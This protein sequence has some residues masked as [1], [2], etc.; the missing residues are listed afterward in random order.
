MSTGFTPDRVGPHPGHVRPTAPVAVIAR[1]KSPSS[2]AW[3]LY[4]AIMTVEVPVYY[5]ANNSVS[6]LVYDS[7]GLSSAMVIYVGLRMNRPA[8]RGPWLGFAMGT[9]LF[10]LGDVL[11]Y[12]MLGSAAPTVS[13]ANILYLAAYPAFAIGMF[14]LV[15]ARSPKAQFISTLDGLII[16]LA[17][18]A[19]AWTFVLGQYALDDTM[20]VAARF[21]AIIYPTLDIMLVVFVVRLVFS[22]GSRNV[23]YW[24]LLSSVVV[25][26][27][28]DTL[29]TFATVHNWFSLSFANPIDIGWLASYALWGASAL[30]PS[31]AN[32]AA[33]SES[34]QSRHPRT[35]LVLL[36]AAAMTAPIAVVVRELQGEHLDVGILTV[37]SA[38]IFALIVV[39]M[40]LVSKYLESAND[41]LADAVTRQTVFANTAEALVGASDFESVARAGVSAAVALSQ[42]VN[43]WATFVVE[44]P[45]VPIVV[46]ECG[47]SLSAPLLFAEPVT[48]DNEVRGT[49]NVG[50]AG[51]VH[52]DLSP[53]FRLIS[54]EMGLALKGVESTEERFRQ[55]NER[56]FR[57]LVQKST[58]LVTLIDRDGRILYQSPCVEDML[59]RNPEHMIGQELSTLVHPDDVAAYEN[60]LTKIRRSK[61]QDTIE[62]E[63]R[64]AHS[65]GSWRVVDSHMTNLLDDP[66]VGAILLNSRDVTDRRSLEQQLQHQAFHDSLT[67]LANRAL[68]IDRLDRALVRS[69]R[70]TASVAV[71]FLDVDDFKSI[72]DSLGHE[73]GDR[74]LVA[75]GE[76]LA[77]EIRLGDT[78]ARIGGDEFAV[79]VDL[80]ASSESADAIATRILRAFDDG[81]QI[82][83]E[84]VSVQLSIGI[85]LNGPTAESPDV[86]VRNAD[87]AMYTAKRKGKDRCETFEEEMYRDAAHRYDLVTDLRHALVNGELEVYYQPIIALLDSRVVGAEAL[88]RWNRRG[89]GMIPAIEFIEIAESTQLIIPL[90]EWV[91]DQACTQS[92]Q[93]KDRG[94]VDDAFFMSVNLSPRQ[95]GDPNI[96]ERVS[97][98]LQSSKLPA[99]A[100]VLEITES[101]ILLEGELG[102]DQIHRLKSL[103]VRL[104][105]DDY[106]TGYSSLSRLADLPLEIVKIDKSFI[107]R[108]T[109]EGAGR[110]LVQSIIDVTSALGMSCIAEGVELEAQ[111]IALIE[112]GCDNMQGYLFSEPLPA[113]EVDLMLRVAAITNPTTTA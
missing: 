90:G 62:L 3:W 106:G 111:R 89:V 8:K 68:F 14:L 97:S 45:L 92:Q 107:D 83:N 54:V 48:V 15:R 10:A 70:H 65:D 2:W 72:N 49:L 12:A 33:P 77:L 53:L 20:S 103:G 23:S 6:A 95:L 109:P 34:H 4:L 28:A 76:R 47:Q 112:M 108:L 25:M 17:V 21:V 7:Y 57:S 100:L 82:G 58:E 88:V 29:S 30:H 59:G 56:R 22:A 50:V 93:W 11:Y 71:M 64:M 38:I 24:L 42:D 46:A 37:F 32:L 79:I 91:L 1:S 39:R 98:A 80:G 35:T 51:G 69:R 41:L 113:V 73:A 43:A 66:D 78:L 99:N 27:T 75:V 74:V 52:D 9:G 84:N 13:V 101:S 102:L 104:A 110:A 31:M 18:G 36:G 67:G 86:L 44:G 60:Q 55:R 94:V 105:I 26:L 40:W 16:T 19:L 63:C 61:H 81:V 87:L 5:L 96:V 85:A